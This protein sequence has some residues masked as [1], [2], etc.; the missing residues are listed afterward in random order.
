MVSFYNLAFNKSTIMHIAPSLNKRPGRSR[1]LNS[2]LIYPDN[3]GRNHGHETFADSESLNA[4]GLNVITELRLDATWAWIAY[5]H[6]THP[7][8]RIGS[9]DREM[10]VHAQRRG[11]PL[12]TATDSTGDGSYIGGH[13]HSR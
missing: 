8:R 2:T 1:A 6:S 4:G 9:W 13:G 3:F 11:L 10:G 5:E 7:P 12:I